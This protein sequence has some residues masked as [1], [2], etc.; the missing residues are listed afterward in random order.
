MIVRTKGKDEFD[1]P[2]I[3]VMSKQRLALRTQPTHSGSTAGLKDNM[4]D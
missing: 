2:S 3:G 4:R 1:G